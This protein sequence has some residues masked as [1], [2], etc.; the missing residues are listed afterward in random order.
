MPFMDDKKVCEHPGKLKGKLGEC[1]AEQI[2]E[3]HGDTK[4]HPCRDKK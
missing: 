3:C 4:K 2:R 1:S